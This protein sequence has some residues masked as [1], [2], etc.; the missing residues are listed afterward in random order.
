MLAP[1]YQLSARDQIAPA[2]QLP[3]LNHSQV[4]GD[5]TFYFFSERLSETLYIEQPLQRLRRIAEHSAMTISTAASGP[6]RARGPSC[7]P[8]TG[9]GR[10]SH[11]DQAFNGHT[12]RA[13]DIHPSQPCH[14]RAPRSGGQ[15]STGPRQR[16][17]A[18]RAR[19]T[20]PP[21][22]GG[23][24]PARRPTDFVFNDSISMQK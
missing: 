21:G 2:Y 8:V 24:G 3:A 22:S 6:G 19:A 5:Q 7:E 23:A 14:C 15:A 9:R 4:I 10:L 17:R 16:R 12:A 18:R 20:R 1:A 11:V 13:P